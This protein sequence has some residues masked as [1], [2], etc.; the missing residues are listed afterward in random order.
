[1]PYEAD[2]HLWA[3][4]QLD[5]V[6]QI[7]EDHLKNHQFMVSDRITLADVSVQVHFSLVST[8]HTI[9]NGLNSIPI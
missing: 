7:F 2:A 3:K 9:K 4:K 6:A 1:M 5:V 8:L